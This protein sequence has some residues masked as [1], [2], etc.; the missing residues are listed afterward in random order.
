MDDLDNAQRILN[1]IAEARRR[2]PTKVLVCGSRDWT[3]RETIREW[4]RKLPKG[5]IVVH[6]NNGE[7]DHRGVAIKGADIIAGDEASAVDFEVRPYPA[8]WKEYGDSAG[9]KRN[10]QMVD[11]EQ[12]D[13]VIAFTEALMRGKGTMTRPTGT[14]DCVMRALAAGIRVTIIPARRMPKNP[15]LAIGCGG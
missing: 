9:P 12:P 3:D 1:S 4:I 7:R 14:T 8:S 5:S 6:G 10:Q 11:V 13:V 2:P 15:L